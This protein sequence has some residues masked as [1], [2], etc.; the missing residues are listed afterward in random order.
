MPST[1]HGAFPASDA[2]ECQGR[3]S[4]WRDGGYGGCTRFIIRLFCYSASNRL[5]IFLAK[6]SLIS[7][8]RGTASEMPFLGFI[9]ME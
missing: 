4:T 8:C 1:R 6:G 5:R 7:L 3:P 9:Q 2:D